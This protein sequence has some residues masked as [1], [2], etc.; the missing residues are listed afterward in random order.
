[1]ID[2]EGLVRER[3]GA[4]LGACDPRTTSPEAFWA[5]QFDTGLAWVWFPSG[6]G[7]L[8]IDPGLQVVADEA[9]AQAGAPSNWT[10]NPVGLGAAAA[11]LAAAGT[12]EQR[13]RWLRPLFT[14]AEVW[15]QLY[16][17]PA[18]GSDLA[19][20]ATTATTEGDGWAVTGHKVFTTLA[21]VARWGLLLARTG[22]GR[23]GSRHGGLTCFVVDME[24]EGVA[25]RPLRQLDG[26]AEFCDV[27]LEGVVVP[28]RNR[29]GPVGDGWAVAVATL[30]N[31]RLAL[32]GPRRGRGEGPIA[33]AVRL[34]RQRGH[35][36]PVLRDRLIRCWIEAEVARLTV[37][38]A[39]SRP[40]HGPGR[41]GPEAAVAKLLAAEVDQRVWELC[42]DLLGPEGALYDSWE[43][44][45][46][47]R[48]GES[49]RDP[50]RAY[51]RSR[52]LTV[53]GGTAEIVR[54]LLA[55]RVLGLPPE[56]ATDG[57]RSSSATQ[58]DR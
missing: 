30:A 27:A 58:D 2:E 8:G 40:A 4:L 42:V 53:Q 15:C 29:L 7:G 18:A 1:V 56:R 55:E 22:T 28:D 36:D 33:E 23:D 41:P 39:R 21:H 35:D 38:R 50:R 12:E 14:C 48:A 31:E 17:E 26:D 54:N 5:G 34:W 16:T 43:P 52:A 57:T 11:A 44:H 32:A 20:L 37:A 51:L 19:A 13:R 6:F 25:V 10:R 46:P 24:E 47:T 9:L 3:V 49:R 45:V